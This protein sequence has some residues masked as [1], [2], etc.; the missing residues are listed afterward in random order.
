MPFNRQSPA[1]IWIVMPPIPKDLRN[2]KIP[3]RCISLTEH[4]DTI[5]SLYRTGTQEELQADIAKWLKITIAWLK[6]EK[7]NSVTVFEQPEVP[8]GN[9]IC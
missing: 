2:K 4:E 7:R 6:R 8:R 9:R 3:C 5:D 1:A